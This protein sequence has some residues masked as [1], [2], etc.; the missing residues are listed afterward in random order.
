MKSPPRP[1]QSF[2]ILTIFLLLFSVTVTAQQ[3]RGT[4]RGLITDE[5]GAVI[6][7]ATVTLTDASGTQKQT[8]TNKDGAY[9]FAGLAFGSYKIKAVAIGFDPS[10]ETGSEEQ[11]SELQPH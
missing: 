9:T 8:T 3:S 4:L 11:T 7:G 6:V 5:F 10:E 1:L 2:S